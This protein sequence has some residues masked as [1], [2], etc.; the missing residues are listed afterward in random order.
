MLTPLGVDVARVNMAAIDAAR[1]D[2]A[3]IDAARVNVAAV[4]ADRVDVAD[5][6]V[7]PSTWLS[8]TW[9][10]QCGRWGSML[11]ID[12]ARVVLPPPL[13]RLSSSSHLLLDLLFLCPV[14]VGIRGGR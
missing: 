9:V 11:G 14:I 4:D 13:R 6:D 1:I 8:S 2:V 3:A 5:V 10:R 12:V 7:T